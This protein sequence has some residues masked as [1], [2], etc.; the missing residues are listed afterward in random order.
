MPH[1]DKMIFA[2]LGIRRQEVFDYYQTAA[3]CMLPHFQGRDLTVRRFPHGIDGPSFFQ[4]HPRR[5][6]EGKGEAIVVDSAGELLAWIGLGVIEWHVPL[7]PSGDP[8][9]HDWAVFDLDPN[10]PAGWAEVGRVAKILLGLLDGLCVPYRIK[11][12]GNRGLHVYIPIQPT[13]QETVVKAIAALS[14]M[15]VAVCP[16]WSTTERRVDRRGARVYLDYLQNG[17]TRTMAGVFT[18]RA[19]RMA[20]VSTPIAAE[21]IAVPPQTWSLR[22][23]GTEIGERSRLFENHG[24]PVDLARVLRRQGI[25]WA[26]GEEASR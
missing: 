9:L 23:V 18:L 24:P 8:R 20:G 22:A 1:P 3:P 10:P 13:A 17:H 7:G 11:T 5:Q 4:K 15:V 12:S 6:Q 26:T 2:D 19:N 14:R 16:E 25:S 21:E